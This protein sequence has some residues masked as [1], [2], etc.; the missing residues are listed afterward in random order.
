MAL[1]ALHK[2]TKFGAGDRVRVTQ[3]ISFGE[4][5]Q[6]QVFEGMVI[7]I[8]GRGRGKSFLVRKIG[9]QQIGI[10]KIFPINAPTVIS[11][12]VVRSGHEGVRQSKLYYTRNKSKREIEQI[13]SRA[14]KK[15]EKMVAKKSKKVIIKKTKTLTKKN[16]S[17]KAAKKK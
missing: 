5:K 10:E 7:S 2:E 13:Y 3:Q 15:G 11:V 14:N 16:A 1:T 17:K 12:E 8:K 4:K 6:T 9:V